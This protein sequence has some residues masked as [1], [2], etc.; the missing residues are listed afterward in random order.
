MTTKQTF[1]QQV[2]EKILKFQELESNN[3]YSVVS[4]SNQIKSKY[5]ISYILNIHNIKTGQSCRIWSTKLLTNYIKT[6]KPTK[7]F[8]FIAQED[9]SREGSFLHPYIEGYSNDSIEY[10]ELDSNSDSD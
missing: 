8:Q 6:K 9:N 3:I 4:Y 2:D 1:K 10:Y 5:G 7:K